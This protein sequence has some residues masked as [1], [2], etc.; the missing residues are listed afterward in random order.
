MIII[1]IEALSIIFLS[2]RKTARGPTFLSLY[3]MLILLLSRN[4][5]RCSLLLICHYRVKNKSIVYVIVSPGRLMGI[6]M[7]YNL[8]VAMENVSP[9]LRNIKKLSSKRLMYLIRYLE[10]PE[11]ALASPEVQI[12]LDYTL[13]ICANIIE[14]Q[15]YSNAKFI[16]ILYGNK[17]VIDGIK[18]HNYTYFINQL[19]NGSK[20]D[21]NNASIAGNS[22]GREQQA[23]MTFN[24]KQEGKSPENSDAKRAPSQN[25]SNSEFSLCTHGQSVS[26]V[27]SEPI[28]SGV[29]FQPQVRPN[30]NQMLKERGDNNPDKLVP[31]NQDNVSGNNQQ[32]P[33][34]HVP[35]LNP[36]N[37]SVMVD[38]QN[39]NIPPQKT[40]LVIPQI[41]GKSQAQDC[42][43]S[44]TGQ[45]QSS[46][47][48]KRES[49]QDTYRSRDSFP[50][51]QHGAESASLLS[52]TYPGAGQGE[53]DTKTP[54]GQNNIDSLTNYSTHTQDIKHTSHA[55]SGSFDRDQGSF[56]VSK[57]PETVDLG[58]INSTHIQEAE[59]RTSASG[60]AL[61][62]SQSSLI[63]SKGPNTA[64]IKLNVS[65]RDQETENPTH[66]PDKS[67]YHDGDS[68]SKRIIPLLR[69]NNL[70][71]PPYLMSEQEVTILYRGLT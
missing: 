57:D 16:H 67:S 60:G 17:D 6:D 50:H 48:P 31:D 35:P 32:A 63:I 34:A 68:L 64:N 36:L 5:N 9:Y 51:N 7:F 49:R 22:D 58:H 23:K 15:I 41:G 21:L 10:L 47:A 24:P 4:S 8:V 37:Q 40:R 54:R 27:E 25:P 13:S 12:C 2:S 42:H 46:N 39:S 14:H 45:S 56:V 19:L 28:Q 44:T 62:R 53:L 11:V 18:D 3:V 52:D 30:D 59:R 29:Y 20:P 38:K 26:C 65:T 33:G 1:N 69:E 66:S 61:D 43:V 70:R 55:L 71:S